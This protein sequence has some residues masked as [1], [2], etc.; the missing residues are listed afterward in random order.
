MLQ[1][2]GYNFTTIALQ[3]ERDK[4]KLSKEL[5]KLRVAAVDRLVSKEQMADN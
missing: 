3:A 4:N 5:A 2:K 1:A